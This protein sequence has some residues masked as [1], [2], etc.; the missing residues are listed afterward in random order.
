MKNWLLIALLFVASASFAQTNLPFWKEVQDFKKQDSISFPAAGQILFIGSSS[1]TKWKDVN[2]Y[3]PG[4]KI[5]NRAFGGSTIA[6]LIQYRYDVLF[7]YNPRQIVM[8]C[9][10]NDF[11]S[12]DTVTVEMVVQRFK[13]FYKFIRDK[14]PAIPFVYVSMKPSPSRLHLVK[15][16]EAANA[17]IALYLKGFKSTAYIDVFNK[18]LLPNGRPKPEIFISDSLHMNASG[19]TIWQKAFIKYLK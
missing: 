1:F 16:F 14:Y 8:Y 2:D 3:F 13:A 7:P 5:L 4:K 18:M 6:D 11:A 19:Y 15:K 9:G 17:M 12:S 10:E